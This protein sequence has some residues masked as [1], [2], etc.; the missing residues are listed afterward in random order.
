MEMAASGMI[1]RI[2]EELAWDTQRRS[3]SQ[4]LQASKAKKFNFAEIEER[5]LNL[6]DTE[7]TYTL[8]T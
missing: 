7:G 2:Y 4:L 5:K 8:I 6:A 3:S 1:K